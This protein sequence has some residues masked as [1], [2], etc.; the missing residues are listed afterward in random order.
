[1]SEDRSTRYTAPLLEIAVARPE[2][3]GRPFKKGK[4]INITVVDQRKEKEAISEY[5]RRLWSIS[6]D[7]EAS[8]ESLFV[9]AIS[10]VDAYPEEERLEHIPFNSIA[11]FTEPKGNRVLLGEVEGEWITSDSF[12]LNRVTITGYCD[13]VGEA[14]RIM[15][16]M[17]DNYSNTPNI[18]SKSFTTLLEAS[19]R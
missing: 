2:K 19:P 9:Q 7:D 8:Q 16:G 15:N 6:I 12:I 17:K 5:N 4:P 14:T 13:T 10:A 18:A 3:Y 11:F 1:M